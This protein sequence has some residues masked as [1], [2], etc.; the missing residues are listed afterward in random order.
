M[1]SLKYVQ[2]MLD[3]KSLSFVTTSDLPIRKYRPKTTNNV[4]YWMSFTLDIY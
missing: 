1:A 3:Y 4:I 2:N